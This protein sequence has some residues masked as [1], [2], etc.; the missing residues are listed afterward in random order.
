[1]NVRVLMTSESAALAE[2]GAPV[3]RFLTVHE[4]CGEHEE[5]ERR[6]YRG[7]GPIT[8]A[9]AGSGEA[10]CGAVKRPLSLCHASLVRGAQRAL[11]ERQGHQLDDLVCERTQR[12]ALARLE[13]ALPVEEERAD[14]SVY[15]RSARGLPTSSSARL[16]MDAQPL[17]VRVRQLSK[18]RSQRIS[19]RSV[20]ALLV[21]G[22]SLVWHTSP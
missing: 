6:H 14:L 3:P 7:I 18:A 15:A 1:M 21:W 22:W 11:H 8:S 19:G 20:W 10:N 17:R 16:E 12:A 4:L 2:A 5:W 13:E 9:P